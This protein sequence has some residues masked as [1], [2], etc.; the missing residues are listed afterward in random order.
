M[1]GE[2]V[3]GE[4]WRNH[5]IFQTRWCDTRLKTEENSKPESLGQQPVVDYV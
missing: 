4:G 3:R 5:I 2:Y 1:Q